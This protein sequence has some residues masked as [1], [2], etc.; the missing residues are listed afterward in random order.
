MSQTGK[1]PKTHHGVQTEFARLARQDVR[2]G[3][4]LVAFLSRSYS[5]KTIAD[6]D[7]GEPAT[8]AEAEA[9]LD[10]AEEFLAVIV[11]CLSDP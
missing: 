8:L 9:S 10:R 11:A 5:L 7:D 6:Y 4:E 2:I 3:R 1:E